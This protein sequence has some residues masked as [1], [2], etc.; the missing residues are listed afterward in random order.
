MG[1]DPRHP[2]E[3]R[4]L[5]VWRQDLP[6]FEAEERA[7]LGL[8]QRLEAL[9]YR[10]Q[11]EKVEQDPVN[12]S[13]SLSRLLLR[14]SF[15]D[16]EM[17]PQPAAQLANLAL[18]IAARLGENE[19]PRRAR[20]LEALAH[21]ALGNARRLLGELHG[22][23]DAFA[24]AATLRSLGTGDPWVE[25]QIL[26][27][28]AVLRRDQHRLDAALILLERALD[29]FRTPQAQSMAAVEE[30][31]GAELALLVK[32]WCLHHAG[33]PEAAPSL[34]EE[35]D[36][37]LDPSAS[38]LLPL[39]LRNGFVWSAIARGQFDEADARLEAALRV[40]SDLN[41]EPSRLQLRWAEARIDLARGETGPAEHGLRAA[42][43]GLTDLRWGV[44]AALV[45]FDL[46]LLYLE[47]GARDS[48]AK[49]SNEPLG[50]LD[51]P[52]IGR[53]ELVQLLR[54]LD[55]CTKGELTAELI[56]S[57]AHQLE[58]SRRPSLAWWSAW[59][60]VLLPPGTSHDTPFGTP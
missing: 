16:C 39:V 23:G 60:T 55:A 12:R 20:D 33:F 14:K 4:Q 26:G 28:E 59:A 30:P 54:F 3:R 32:A 29:L 6:G 22:A 38:T 18:R 9:D 41:H 47:A 36:S 50:A 11:I 2:G 58:R 24:A 15:A 56:E 40:A 52:E 44:D 51:S 57:L 13:W 27:F 43:Q 8:W 19:D 46:A 10:W 5:H 25:A 21:A 49:L 17:R 48:L 1:H 45:W 37:R 53:P 42:A 7:A 34:L 31:L 35:V